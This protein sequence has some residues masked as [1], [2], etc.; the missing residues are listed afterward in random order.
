MFFNQYS[1]VIL[2]GLAIAG[3]LLWAVARGPR[4]ERLVAVAALALG[5][6]LAFLLFAPQASAPPASGDSAASIG[7]GASTLLEFQSPY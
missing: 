7:A 3:L 2:S 6:A 4:T 1:F 5:C